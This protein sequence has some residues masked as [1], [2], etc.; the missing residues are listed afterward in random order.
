M[1]LISDPFPH[2]KM[3]II[4]VYRTGNLPGVPP[5]SEQ[6]ARSRLG[7][8]RGEPC[9]Q[10]AIACHVIVLISRGPQLAGA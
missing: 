4:G 8:W 2:K 9:A 7:G 5:E 10:P 6:A 3:F 1:L